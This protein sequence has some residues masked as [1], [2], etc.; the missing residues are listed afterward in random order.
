LAKIQFFTQKMIEKWEAEKKV[1][2]DGQKLQ[3]LI[4]AKQS[5]QLKAA[6]RFLKL[7]EGEDKMGIQKKVLTKESLKHKAPDANILQEANGQR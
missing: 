1:E 5:Y 7:V 3:V 4:G 2:F 6:T